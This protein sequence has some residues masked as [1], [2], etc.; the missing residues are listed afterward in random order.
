M[1]GRII[2]IL[3]LPLLALQYDTAYTYMEDVATVI[4]FSSPT[5]PTKRLLVKSRPTG[6]SNLVNAFQLHSKCLRIA[7]RMLS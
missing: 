5:G 1:K 6:H 3:T 2:V 7:A 4:F